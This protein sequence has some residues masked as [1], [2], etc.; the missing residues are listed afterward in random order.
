MALVAMA[1]ACA[2]L[3]IGSPS[4]ASAAARLSVT[5]NPVTAGNTATIKGRGFIAGRMVKLG[6]GEPNSEADF[7]QQ[8]RANAS[9]RVRFRVAFN[10]S[11]T[12]GTY[13]AIGCQRQCRRKASKRFR[14][15][16]ASSTH[17]A[18]S[19]A[20]SKIKFT[21]A[22]KIKSVKLKARRAALIRAFG[23]PTTDHHGYMNWVKRHQQHDAYLTKK[24]VTLYYMQGKRYCTSW[25]FCIGDTAQELSDHYGASIAMGVNLDQHAWVVN[26]RV[27]GRK[28]Y[29]AFAVPDFNP[30]SSVTH[31]WMGFCAD[32]T[33]C[34]TF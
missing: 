14:I 12:P 34:D 27:G 18:D 2:A 16:A 9:G 32:T 29:A 17:A 3:L 30:A 5:P 26:S 6:I 10:V 23:K 21:P 4:Q 13:V 15:R 8:R 19:R 25:R 11:A 33:Y 7:I 1:V 28:T 20:L 31:V 22:V 24:R